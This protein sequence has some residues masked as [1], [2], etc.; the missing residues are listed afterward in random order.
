[1][2]NQ[3]VLVGLE[4]LVVTRAILALGL[5]VRYLWR[6]LYTDRIMEAYRY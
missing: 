1:M 4:D 5:Q 2:L 3:K 6:R